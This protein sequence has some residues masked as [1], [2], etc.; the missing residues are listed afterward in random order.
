M[1][2]AILF[3]ALGVMLLVWAPSFSDYANKAFGNAP[4]L[5]SF[6]HVVYSTR[7]LRFL[8]VVWIVLAA[9]ILIYD[10]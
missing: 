2:D 9:A 1:F 4:V 6:A 5:R 8:G 3:A 10:I 7:F